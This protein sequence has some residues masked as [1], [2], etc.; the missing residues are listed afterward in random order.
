MCLGGLSPPYPFQLVLPASAPLILELPHQVFKPIADD[1]VR[2]ADDVISDD[3]G[4]WG[5]V[6]WHVVYR[7]VTGSQC[8]WRGYVAG[9]DIAAEAG[10]LPQARY[11]LEQR[12]L[13]RLESWPPGGVAE[14]LEHDLGGGLWL[15]EALDERVPERANTARVILEA[16]DDERLR[17][18]LATLP[19][20]AEGGIVV[21]ACVPGNGLGWLGEQHDRSG[22]LVAATALTN[23]RLWWNA[24]APAGCA[25]AAGL[26]VAGSLG[27][28]GLLDPESTVD[29]W[30][31]AAGCGHLVT[32]TA[33]A[34]ARSVPA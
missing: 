20:T 9:E 4:W 29:D 24:L 30:V 2:Q 28:L 27:G 7:C 14:H 1:N 26:P 3:E 32:L 12:L 16:F 19:E 25:P 31:A 34:D 5:A 17:R 21:L 18:R 23:H 13:A 8:R 6:S 11:E 33:P 15:R 10:A 22:T